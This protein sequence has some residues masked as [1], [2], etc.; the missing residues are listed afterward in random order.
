MYLEPW[1]APYQST[2][3]REPAD[4]PWVHMAGGG[5]RGPY[6]TR[7]GTRTGSRS[8]RCNLPRGLVAIVGFVIGTGETAVERVICDRLL[9]EARWL[10]QCAD[11]RPTCMPASSP[12]GQ[13]ASQGRSP[14]QAHRVADLPWWPC[15]CRGL[16]PISMSWPAPAASSNSRQLLSC[17]AARPDSGAGRPS[18]T[19]TSG[20]ARY[21]LILTFIVL[22]ITFIMLIINCISLIN[23]GD[24]ATA[25]L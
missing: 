9:D 17:P 1:L 22:M 7:V 16:P 24:A 21:L 13:L 25:V 2:R 15:S 11:C 8:G 5:Y 14:G 18:Q 23:Q 6:S 12:G 4:S 10:R 20:R 3:V 19:W